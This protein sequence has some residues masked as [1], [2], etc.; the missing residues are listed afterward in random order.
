MFG[1]YYERLAL[2]RGG[3]GGGATRFVVQ[4]AVS[5]ALFAAPFGCQP[6][7]QCTGNEAICSSSTQFE[8]CQAIDGADTFLGT[9]TSFEWGPPQPCPPSNPYCVVLSPGGPPQCVASP[10]PVAECP[11]ASGG[12]MPICAH[13]TPSSCVSGYL[14]S[15]GDTCEAGTCTLDVVGAAGEQSS[16]CAYCNDGTYFPD[17][18]CAELS[19]GTCFDGGFYQCNCGLRMGAAYDCA[20]ARSLEGPSGVCVTASV[21]GGTESFCAGSSEPDP[22]CDG[23]LYCSETEQITLDCKDGYVLFSVPCSKCAGGVCLQYPFDD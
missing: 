22:R 7:H 12:P 20:G 16:S 9:G 19:D 14:F 13:N 5:G 1:S 10:A 23:G 11:D 4:A 17:P 2:L 6:E 21:A 8:E 15:T 18:L 3:T